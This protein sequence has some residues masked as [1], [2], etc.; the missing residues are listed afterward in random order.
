MDAKY[1]VDL[2]YESSNTDVDSY[3]CNAIVY[4]CKIFFW[5]FEAFKLR[6]L[7]HTHCEGNYCDNEKHSSKKKIYVIFGPFLMVLNANH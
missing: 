2:F 5:Q 7:K 4:V 3:P 1:V 6:S